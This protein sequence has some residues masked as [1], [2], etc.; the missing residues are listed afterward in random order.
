[1]LCTPEPGTAHR[2]SPGHAALLFPLITG[3]ATLL[4][5]TLVFNQ[6]SLH[7]FFY[8]WKTDV[9]RCQWNM[10]LCN[11]K[12]NYS[13][14]CSCLVVSAK[15][16]QPRAAGCGRASKSVSATS[17][18]LC[19]GRSRRASWLSVLRL[20]KEMGICTS[21]N[22]DWRSSEKRHQLWPFYC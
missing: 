7:S 19:K 9:C 18:R 10:M 4:S 22:T 12:M 3:R 20:L 11:T 6:N 21:L 1:M 13:Y 8:T 16:Q 14:S 15:E 17:W 2:V 5:S